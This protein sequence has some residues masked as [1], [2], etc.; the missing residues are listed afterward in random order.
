MQNESIP[1]LPGFQKLSKMEQ[2]RYVQW[3]WD[4]IAADSGEVPVP[5]SHMLVAEERLA[6]HRSDPSQAR[7][8][9]AVL[10]RLE[11]RSR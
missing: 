2:V 6:A 4:Y 9:Y 8:A 5:E 3:L 1:E 11:K 7:P 10:D